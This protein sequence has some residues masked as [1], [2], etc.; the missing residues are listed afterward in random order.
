MKNSSTEN[1]LEDF[2]N[3]YL[4]GEYS[5]AR[6]LLLKNKSLFD[7]GVFHYNLGTV[8]LKEK[9]F[10]VAR[11]HLEKAVKK[12]FLNGRTL[13]N[14]ELSREKLSVKIIENSQSVLSNSFAKLVSAPSSFF[15]MLTLTMVLITLILKRFLRNKFI[16]IVCLLISGTP[17]LLNELFFD[18][19]LSAVALK[20]IKVQEGP[21]KI[22]EQKTEIPEG[23]KI[24]VKK[25]K[26]GWFYIKHPVDLSGWIQGKDL[27]VL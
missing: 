4:K 23:V 8:F 10:A 11:Y 17:I 14:L 24:I 3:H 16:F 27:G 20:S 22:F 5:A 18:S 7:Q 12:G 25:P 9:E 1:I 2:Q 13:N 15:I 26:D 6:E 19:Y 21:S